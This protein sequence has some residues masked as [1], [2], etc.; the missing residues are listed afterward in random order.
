M[1]ARA[2]SQKLGVSQDDAKELVDEFRT[3]YPKMASFLLDTMANAEEK[4]YCHTISGRR[5]YFEQYKSKEERISINTTVQVKFLS[6]K[7]K[8]GNEVN[9]DNKIL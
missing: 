3:A 8:K 6:P 1:G 4:K 9:F 7:S 2:L 5:R